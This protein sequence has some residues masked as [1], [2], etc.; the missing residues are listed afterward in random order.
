[1]KYSYRIIPFDAEDVEYM[2]SWLS[3]MASRGL[4]YKDSFARVARFK[5]GG[6]KRYRYRLEPVGAAPECMLDA[7]KKTPGR[8][9]I[10]TA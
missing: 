3:D 5:K 2:E 10:L 7:G 6:P 9:V 4:F 8:A 1:M